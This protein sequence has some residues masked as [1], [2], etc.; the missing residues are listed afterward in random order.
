MPPDDRAAGG[1]PAP[2]APAQPDDIARER[3]RAAVREAIA[4]GKIGHASSF[5]AVRFQIV[6]DV[7]IWALRGAWEEA[8]PEPIDAPPEPVLDAL[9]GLDAPAGNLREIRIQAGHLPAQVAAL[10]VALSTADRNLFQRDG[11]LVTIIRQPDRTEV[12]LC[13]GRASTKA[14]CTSC[15]SEMGVSCVRDHRRGVDILMRPGTPRV[16]PLNQAVLLLRSATHASWEK[17]DG[18]RKGG[19]EWVQA[20]PCTRTV[21]IV[22]GLEDW[23]GIRPLKGI[24]ETPAL[25]PSG[26]VI[27][28]P[29][30]DDETGYMLL[31]S[32]K[33]A[34]IAERPTKEQACRALKYLWIELA[35]DFPFKGLG[36]ADPARDPDRELQFLR[37]STCP[38]AFVGI[39]MLLTIFARPAILGAVPGGLFEAAGQGSGKSIQIHGVSIVATSRPAGVATFPVRDGRPDEAEL[40]KVIAG[41]A[42]AAARIVAFDN[43]KGM[44]TGAGLEKVLTAVDTIDIRVLGAND[45]R[46]LPW[47]AVSMFSGNNLTMSDDIAQRMLL[48]R[49]VSRREDP[50]SRPANTFRHPELLTAIRARRHHLVRAVLTILRAFLCAQE[51]GAKLEPLGTWGSFEAWSRL[52]PPALAFAGGPN[53]LRARPAAGRGGDEE[54]QA[55]AALMRGWR[56]TWQLQPARFICSDAFKD[57]RDIATNQAPDDGLGDVR[58]AIRVLTRTAERATPNGHVLGMKLGQIREKVREGRR[59]VQE[60]DKKTSTS[61]WRVEEEKDL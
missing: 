58:A 25:A 15:G 1:T 21:N 16:R 43:I 31:P 48:S 5:D 11:A 17:F 2:E 33:I 49:I 9:P 22:H 55:H 47:S 24:L 50:R 54:G 32:C 34:P 37:A 26:R 42:L 56:S 12:A 44:L 18:R 28:A 40:E 30:Y 59:I 61:L 19:G 38:D 60:E 27:E 23:P 45:Q 36:E 3:A 46:T 53:I 41:Y 20:D 35:C 14:P 7:P 13:A 57:E 29:G 10:V 6:S 8:R 4:A 39:T 51:D 52:I